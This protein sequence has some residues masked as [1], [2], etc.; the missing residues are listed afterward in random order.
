MAITTAGSSR[1]TAATRCSNDRR[2]KRPVRLSV[3]AWSWVSAMTRSRPI[4]APDSLASV[5]RSCTVFSENAGVLL[6]GHMD[7]AD[8]TAHDRDGHAHRRHGPFGPAA[9]LRARVELLAVGEPLHLGPTRRRAMVRRV[10]ATVR[11]CARGRGGRHAQEMCVAVV[12]QQQL[13]GRVRHNGGERP[14]NDLDHLWLPFGHVQGVGQA[15]LEP[16]AP[17]LRFELTGQ[18]GDDAVALLLFLETA[19]DKC[20]GQGSREHGKPRQR[21]PGSAHCPTR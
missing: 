19:H 15:A 12:R 16:L 9:Q 1:R 13:S 2:F 20:R 4:R 6:A 11:W 5:S 17:R 10:D 3:V 8:G 7:D 14:L 21:S 18:G